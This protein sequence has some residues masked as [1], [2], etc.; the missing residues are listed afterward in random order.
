MR[1]PHLLDCCSITCRS[2]SNSIVESDKSQLFNKSLD[3]PNEH[4]HELLECYYCHPEKDHIT[5]LSKLKPGVSSK[6]VFNGDGYILVHRNDLISI[7]DKSVSYTQFVPE[8]EGRVKNFI[9]KKSSIE[10]ENC[11][12]VLG[13]LSNVTSGIF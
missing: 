6:T 10:C 4:W 8:P 12:S 2:C 5:A 1:A 3:L 11:Q 9:S 7:S 13:E